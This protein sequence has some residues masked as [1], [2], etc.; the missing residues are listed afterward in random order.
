MSIAAPPSRPARAGGA[1]F[2]RHQGLLFLVA[3]L[4]IATPVSG[5]DTNASTGG[6]ATTIVVVRHAE[7]ESGSSDDPP[8]SEA[9][10]RR[11]AELAAAVRHAGIS[12]V[13]TTQLR[14]T[15]E[16]AAPLVQASSAASENMA[17]ERGAVAAHIEAIRKRVA[18][19]EPDRGI[20]I[21]AHS[22]TVP[23]IVEA[24]SG[25]AVAEIGHHE[26]D[27]LFLIVL[28]RDRPPRLI[29]SRYGAAS[30]RSIK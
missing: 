29:E 25:I 3:A 20:A 9:G 11:A 6:P 8:L 30:L 21:V 10:R 14:R 28:E 22:N 5:L 26:Y 4:L 1:S 27:R 15:I 23:L 17:V 12:L 7:A 16:T 18:A 24:L 13:L 19:E 2:L